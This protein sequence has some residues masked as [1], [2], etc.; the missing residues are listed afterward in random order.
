MVFNVKLDDLF[1]AG[2]SQKL[3]IPAARVVEF[4]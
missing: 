1:Y 2:N 4:S 3:N